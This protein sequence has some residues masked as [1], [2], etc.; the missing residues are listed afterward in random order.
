MVHIDMMIVSQRSVSQ[1][2]WILDSGMMI[3]FRTILK[4][5]LHLNPSALSPNLVT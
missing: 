1:T 2:H 4:I 5:C 3:A